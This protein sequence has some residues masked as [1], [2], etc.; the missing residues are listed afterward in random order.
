MK[1][2]NELKS[3]HVGA[4]NDAL[5]IINEPPRP[6]PVDYH[7]DSLKTKVIAKVSEPHEYGWSFDQYWAHA[8]LLA[9]APDL[10]QACE[11]LLAEAKQYLEESGGGCDHSVGICCCGLIGR[12]EAGESA[13]AKAKQP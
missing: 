5:F 12:I 11:W 6:A 13:I 3:W 7:N 4:M 10:L 8:N 9:A 1:K 2:E